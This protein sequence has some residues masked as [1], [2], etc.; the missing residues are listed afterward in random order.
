MNLLLDCLYSSAS[1][2]LGALTCEMLT[3]KRPFN[4]K[5]QKELDRNILSE[6]FV[7]PSTLK[8]DTVSLLKGLLEKDM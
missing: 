2:S 8:P 6:K 7:P 1:R 4:G 3:G 5:T